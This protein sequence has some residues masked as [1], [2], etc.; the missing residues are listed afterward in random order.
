MRFLIDA[1]LPPALAR[2]LTLAGHPAEAVR[3]LGLHESSDATIWDYAL[4]Q[5]MTVITKDE[6]FADRIWRTSTGPV[7][8]WLRMGN[9]S[10]QALLE[11]L[12]PVI[13]HIIERISLGDRLIE[14]S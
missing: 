14:V 11:H 12:M 3:D 13:P 1:Q 4:K 6:D 10:N 5:Q 2:E 7:I 9:C 8:V